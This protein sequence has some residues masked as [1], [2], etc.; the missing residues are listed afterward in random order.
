MMNANQEIKKALESAKIDLL[1]NF[2]FFGLLASKM[3]IVEVKSI[4]TMATD[5]K[6]IYYNPDF[7][8]G[9]SHDNR[10]FAFAHELGHC[11]YN[12][13]IRR[14][15]RDREYWNMAGDYAINYDLVHEQFEKSDG[16]RLT[17][18]GEIRPEWLYESRFGNMASEQIYE[19]LVNEKYPKKPT[20][21]HHL[22]PTE[23]KDDEEDDGEI[24]GEE[25]DIEALPSIPQMSDEAAN[26]ARDDFFRNVFNAEAAVNPGQV[27]GKIR[28]LIGE[29]K[30]PKK[31]WR[32]ALKSTIESA[33]KPHRTWM[34]PHRR[35]W[36][37]GFVMPGPAPE[38][39]INV[40][41]AIDLSASISY[42]TATDLFSEVAGIMQQFKN[43]HIWIWTFDTRVYASSMVEIDER[44][45]FDLAEFT[46]KGGGGTDFGCNWRFMQKNRIKPDR[47]LM[48]TD[49]YCG[50]EECD[51]NYVDTFWL[52]HSNPNFQAPFGKVAQY[53]SN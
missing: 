51:P 48:F 33:H 53:D 1:L 20:Q 39:A 30:H 37:Q 17:G 8:K 29:L 43:Y 26:Q 47:F 49:G 31:N 14:E 44:T 19:I 42:K 46:P 27:P 16:T 7:V 15:D 24:V 38:Q 4:P 21:D 12:H 5:Y 52:I 13:F 6:R 9:L 45:G 34:N 41:I 18:V 28:R 35:T 3:P 10:V 50:F 23:K 32:E 36:S 22:E 25:E 40:A 2:P 11:I